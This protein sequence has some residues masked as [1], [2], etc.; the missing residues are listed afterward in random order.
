MNVGILMKLISYS[1]ADPHDTNDIE[2]ALFGL[3]VKCTFHLYSIACCF[4]DIGYINRKRDT[5]SAVTEL[6]NQK[7]IRICQCQTKNLEK[8]H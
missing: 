8:S 1:L 7:C 5:D 2:K 6:I 4:S 3:S